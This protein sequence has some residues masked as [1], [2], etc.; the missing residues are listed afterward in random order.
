MEPT[1]RPAAGQVETRRFEVVGTEGR[2]IRGVVPYGVESRDMGGWKEVI[3]PGALRQANLDELVARVD[4]QGVP[5]GRFPK[6]L[7]PRGTIGRPALVGDPAES[8]ADLREAVERGDLRRRQ[9]AD[10]RRSRPL[11]RRHPARR[12]DRRASR[13]VDR[14]PTPLIPTASVE[15]RRRTNHNHRRTKCPRKAPLRC[16]PRRRATE[17]KSDEERNAP[18]VKVVNE[19]DARPEGRGPLRARSRS[20]RSPRRSARGGS[21]ARRRRLTG[22][23][24]GSA[25]FAAA[26]SPT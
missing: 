8:R 26:R 17:D 21:P 22:A 12:G 20:D 19:P 23:S 4:H 3:E 6:T 13:R 2:K 14:E 15:Y 9:L 5:I 7:R 1:E 24:S 25:T 18:E 16:P 11:G 10:G